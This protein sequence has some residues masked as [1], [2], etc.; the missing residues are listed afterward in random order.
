MRAPPP[1]GGLRALLAVKTRILLN[2]ARSIRAEPPLKVAV[3]GGFVA[4]WT[5]GS[6]PM[7]WCT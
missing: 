5:A 3:V 7:A 4:L 2:A 6:P 1:P